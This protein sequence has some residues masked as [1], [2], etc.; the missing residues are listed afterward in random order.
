MTCFLFGT[1][2]SVLFWAV[3]ITLSFFATAITLKIT[4]PKTF[5]YVTGIELPKNNEGVMDSAVFGDKI[6]CVS[7]VIT[8]FVFWPL[9]LTLIAIYYV[10]VKLMV[11]TFIKLLTGAAKLIPTV[12]FEKQKKKPQEWDDDCLNQ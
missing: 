6:D 4:S 12:T 10:I 7:Y 9:M 3:Y 11:P 1:L 8:L 5:S 2:W